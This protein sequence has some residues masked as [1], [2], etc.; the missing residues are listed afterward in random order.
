[1][2]E[3]K[4]S[5]NKTNHYNILLQQRDRDRDSDGAQLVTIFNANLVMS[6]LC[7]SGRLNAASATV[8]GSSA[9][10]T[11]EKYVVLHII[12]MRISLISAV[13]KGHVEK[14]GT[15]H[16]YYQWTMR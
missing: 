4:N 3:K 12:A 15:G 1:M 8:T 10:T 11:G 16:E 13:H 7:Y 5:K 2:P 9:A 14:L 6:V